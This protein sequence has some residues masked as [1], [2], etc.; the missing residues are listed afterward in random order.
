MP[1]HVGA[2]NNPASFHR[3][4]AAG[5]FRTVAYRFAPGGSAPYTSV[6]TKPD[7]ARTVGGEAVDPKRGP[8][9]HVV[10]PRIIRASGLDM[11]RR[12]RCVFCFP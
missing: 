11:K 7:V 2:G 3:Y 1:A 8:K 12:T 6:Q 5:L 9:H 4:A 10:K